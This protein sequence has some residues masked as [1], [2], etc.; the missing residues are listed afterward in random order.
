ML[1][2]DYVATA[3]YLPGQLSA[4]GD[5][6]HAAAMLSIASAI[7]PLRPRPHWRRAQLLA[8]DG[9]IDEAFAELDASKRLGYADTD[10]LRNNTV[11][12][13]LRDDP[14]WAPMLAAMQVPDTTPPDAD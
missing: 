13:P 5:L 3:F 8:A 9:R 12:Q 1:E 10:D 14:R 4:Q 6:S 2:R 11:W 7:F